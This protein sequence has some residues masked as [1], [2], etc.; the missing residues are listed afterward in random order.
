MSA[1]LTQSVWTR[2]VLP[3]AQ[4]ERA[5]ALLR[6]A[7]VSKIRNARIIPQWL[8][9][10][11]RFWY[12]REVEGG[13]EFVL[14][15]ACSGER[16]P[17]FDHG[18]VAAELS[19]LAGAHVDAKQLPVQRIDADGDALK[20]TLE[21]AGLRYVCKPGTPGLCTPLDEA[22]PSPAWLVSPD[23][24][25]A[26]LV[27]EQRLWLRDIATGVER[28]LVE[29][30]EPDFGF[31]LTPDAWMMNHIPRTRSG[32]LMPPF[33][34]SWSPDSRCIVVPLVDQ[35]HVAPYPFVED[36]PSDGSFRPRAHAVRL[37]LAGEPSAK[38]SWHLIDVQSGQR[39]RIAY[40]QEWDVA[41]ERSIV[42]T[43]WR[44]DGRGFFTMAQTQERDIT[45]LFA[46][47]AADGSV[48]VCIEDRSMPGRVFDGGGAGAPAVRLLEGGREIIWLSM[49]D[50]WA[51]LYRYDADTGLQINR[52]TSG[53]WSVRDI[54]GLDEARR[55]VYFTACG[56]EPGNP[57]H[58]RL[59]RS[60]LDGS[61][62]QLIGLDPGDHQLVDPTTRAAGLDGVAPHEAISPSGDHVVVSVSS[63]GSPAV[64][65]IRRT[66][67]GSQV[68]CVES[69]DASALFAAGYR[70][71]QEMTLKAADGV[72]DLNGL[73]YRPSDHDPGRRYAVIDVQYA[74]PLVAATPRDFNQAAYGMIDFFPCAATAELGFIVVVVDARGTPNRSQAFSTP[75]TGYL[76]TM[77]LDDHVAFIR[78]LAQRDPSVDLGRV[79]ISGIS[80]GGWAS[81]RGMLTFPDFFKVGVAGA[82]PGRFQAMY[83]IPRLTTAQG[84]I[85]YD[86][87]AQTTRPGPTAVPDGFDDIDCA[88]HV[89]RLAGK[90]LLVMGE[91][92][93][94]VLP[95]ST[96]QFFDAAMKADKD[97]ELIYLPNATHFGIYTPYA[98]R[99]VWS[100]LL[101]HLNGT[102][103]PPGTRLPSPIPQ[104]R[105]QVGRT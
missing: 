18:E 67:D 23:G 56:R 54:V 37:A 10:P 12:R 63:V 71:P 69:A 104:A 32:Q 11:D 5:I 52:I 14:V 47:D 22:R 74:S 86:G 70:P 46:V 6:P 59:Y 95:G 38:L 87:G 89:E 39:Q 66:A 53:P 28:A 85:R 13:I 40:A 57:Y 17:A 15:D 3:D 19:A 24:T 33:Q 36:V 55:T 99:R 83:G 43:W 51:H 48:R 1:H 4:L 103:L 92:D 62:V 79:G 64:S 78:E 68:A 75:A 82:P 76:T 97:V 44:T 50:G 60:D 93:E 65:T 29:E 30:G 98:M 27:Q 21:H 101:E 2:P 41:T 8:T 80:F 105:P 42:R 58:R 34:G 9:G 45:Y 31:G 81:L 88:K 25:S 84:P 90:L 73:V 91:Q 26:L 7:V 96:L 49:Q 102:A 100:F 16:R 77:G 20:V 72:T 94:N 61:A 35:R